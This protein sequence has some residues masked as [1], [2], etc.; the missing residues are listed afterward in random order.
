MNKERIRR[1]EERL[2][3]ARLLL[4]RHHANVE[5]DAGFADRVAARLKRDPAEMLGWAALRL[6][7]ASLL[8][9]LVL[10][11]VS[12]RVAARQEAGGTQGA[13]EDVLAWVLDNGERAR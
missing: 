6:L 1:D 10:G 4:Q 8:L 13:D 2:L 5:P 12:F 11:W 7:P 3:Q 9:A